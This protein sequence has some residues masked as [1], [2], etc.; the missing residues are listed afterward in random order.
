MFEA[1]VIKLQDARITLDSQ[2]M[3]LGSANINM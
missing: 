3:A 2:I 1:E